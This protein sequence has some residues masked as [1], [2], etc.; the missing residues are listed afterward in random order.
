[1]DN[2][3]KICRWE[4][5]VINFSIVPTNT[6]ISIYGTGHLQKQQTWEHWDSDNW[7]TM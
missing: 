6:V 3:K 2:L 5:F 4:K 7:L 1:M